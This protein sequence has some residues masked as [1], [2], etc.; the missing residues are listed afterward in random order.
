MD[1]ARSTPEVV[2][3]LVSLRV[4]F[5]DGKLQ[6]AEDA[7]A[8]AQLWDKLTVALLQVMRFQKYSESRW[9]TVGGTMRTLVASILLGLS[10][11]VEHTR[12]DPSASDYFIKG[13]TRLTN[14]GLKF[15]VLASICA[16]VG[17]GFLSEVLADSRIPMRRTELE[18]CIYEELAY[19]S[20]LSEPVIQLLGQT[21]C[22]PPMY[23][24]LC[25]T[26]VYSVLR[27]NCHGSFAQE[28]WP[29]ILKS[30]QPP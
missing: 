25:C 21:A 29:P 26:T 15:A 23:Q 24:L 19:V 17:D 2:E 16:H 20:Q 14:T 10:S 18:T 7:K 22:W 8:D 27:R 1:V 5:R 9:L 11:L 6:V 13:Y 4:L 30:L 28:I 12:S 3:L